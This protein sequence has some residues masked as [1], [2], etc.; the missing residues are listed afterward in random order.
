[1][2]L[3]IVVRQ[4]LS[5]GYQIAQSLHAFREYVEHHPECERRWYKDSNTIV[6]LGCKD[7]REL[8]TLRQEASLRGLKTA[9]FYEPDL[10]DELTACAFE[11]GHRSSELLVHLRSALKPSNPEG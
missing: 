4:D 3:Y 1:M 7:E 6:I 5:P 9:P 2:K 11:P 8:D 10:F